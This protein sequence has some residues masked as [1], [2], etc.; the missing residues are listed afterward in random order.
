MYEY[1]IRELKIIRDYITDLHNDNKMPESTMLKV[2]DFENA[3]R[4]L[5][6]ANK[7]DKGIC[8]IDV[9][10]MKYIDKIKTS[11][12]L[13]NFILKYIVEPVIYENPDEAQIQY[14][15][16]LFNKIEEILKEEK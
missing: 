16:R 14:Y 3:I 5:D 12:E 7:I 10:R 6:N 1:A 4:L 11:E 15:M 8:S 2:R 9:E 13:L